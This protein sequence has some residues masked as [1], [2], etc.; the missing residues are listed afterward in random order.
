MVKRLLYRLMVG[1]ITFA[2]GV[3]IVSI[4]KASRAASLCELNA[5]PASYSGK[6]IRLRAVLQRI[7]DVVLA[8][9]DCVTEEAAWASVELGTSDLAKLTLDEPSK[10]SDTVYQRIHLT[11]AIVV[12][13]LDPH[14]GLGCFA[15]KYRVTNARIER[16]ISS[17]EFDGLESSVQWLKSNSY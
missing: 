16:I 11:D 6:T 4:W 5:N 3:G 12:G 15:P 10:S 2:A 7:P 13:E 17:N 8:G 9:S 14:F 1:L